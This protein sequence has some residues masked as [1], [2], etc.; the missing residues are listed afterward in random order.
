MNIIA[1]SS[2]SVNG[3]PRPVPHRVFDRPHWPRA[4][5]KLIHEMG[6]DFCPIFAYSCTTF[7]F[8]EGNNRFRIDANR[9]NHMSDA[10]S[11]FCKVLVSGFVRF[12]GGASKGGIVS[13]F[14]QRI[15]SKHHLDFATRR[16]LVSFTP[17]HRSL[18]PDLFLGLILWL[19]PTEL[20]WCA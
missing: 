8:P 14:T 2:L 17:Q 4:W 3:R 15:L 9:T 13:R 6:I 19:F 20:K 1:C 7:S 5:N 12:L 18:K 10:A 11:R 16:R